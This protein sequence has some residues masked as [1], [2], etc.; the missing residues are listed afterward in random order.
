MIM[1]A[2]EA[3]PT[4]ISDSD[5]ASG[6]VYPGLHN[7]RDI[8]ANIACT[9]IKTAAA[10]GRVGGRAAE[11]LAR[12]DEVLKDWITRNMF[13]PKYSSLTHQPVGVGE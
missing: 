9:V 4:L 13:V 6:A 5:V 11:R 12:G 1:A 7:I 8:T 2:A 10:E 3:L